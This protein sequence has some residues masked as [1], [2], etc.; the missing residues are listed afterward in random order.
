MTFVGAFGA[1]KTNLCGN[2]MQ[3]SFNSKSD[4]TTGIKFRYANAVMTESGDGSLSTTDMDVGPLLTEVMRGGHV[5][6]SVIADIMRF[7][8]TDHLTTSAKQTSCS[9]NEQKPRHSVAQDIEEGKGVTKTLEQSVTVLG[10]SETNLATG[11][12]KSDLTAEAEHATLEQ[13]LLKEVE[14]ELCDSRKN[15]IFVGLLDCGGQLSFSVVQTI[16]F[17]ADDNI[18]ILTYNS[19]IPLNDKIPSVFRQNGK[20][21]TQQMPYLTNAEHI[22]LWLS[23]LFMLKTPTTCPL[24]IVV[25]T[26]CKDI[27]KVTAK[28]DLQLLLKD[29]KEDLDIRGPFFVDNS[30]P[31]GRDMVQFRLHMADFIRHEIKRKTQTIPLSY[32]K[33]EW[34]IR[35]QRL[36]KIQTV[37]QFT[38]F[39]KKT[40]SIPSSDVQ[41]LLKY[42]HSHCAV[43]FFNHAGYDQQEA[44][45]YLN[46]PWLLEQVCKLLS[47]TMTEALETHSMAVNSDVECLKTKGILTTR[48]AKHLWTDNPGQADFHKDLLDILYCLGLQC[49]IEDGWFLDITPE[50]GPFY[51]VP[52]CIKQAKADVSELPEAKAMP[53]LQQETV[54]MP[55]LL[56]YVNAKVK[57]FPFGEFS[58]L[59]GLLLQHYKPRSPEIGTFCVRFY[60]N[61]PTK[62]YIAEV[63][64]VRRGVAVVLKCTKPKVASGSIKG[65]SSMAHCATNFL[66]TVQDKLEKLHI[67]GLT[68]SAAFHCPQ[69]EGKSNTLLNVW[70]I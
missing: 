41:T 27:D 6:S 25:G 36:A 50:A 43:R 3:P 54:V 31:K 17:N 9:S 8:N 2:L 48:L 61:D 40:A 63:S 56:L 62:C 15:K 39:A 57:F 66:K 38:S 11:K 21:Y 42:L 22:T 1:G 19:S 24:V 53:T 29:F 59:C 68:W 33:C 13:T 70:K 67:N 35:Q 32:L 52:V 16:C 4:S 30:Q 5:A 37:S 28:A 23:T 46:V 64:H 69:H 47:C 65:C 7:G 34:L 44:R 49:P 18:F 51:Y 26:F 10:K 58:R 12:D 20:H 45:V 55:A 14:S 60:L